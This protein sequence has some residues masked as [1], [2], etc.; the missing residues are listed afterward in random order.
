MASY[1]ARGLSP[2][3]QE[4][5][6]Y[7]DA[8]AI[9]PAQASQ[10]AQLMSERGVRDLPDNDLFKA[11]TGA[12]RVRGTTVNADGL[13]SLL[14]LRLTT[15][16][17]VLS[18]NGG[19]ENAYGTQ[20]AYGRSRLDANKPISF[21]RYVAPGGSW[22]P[23]TQPGTDNPDV[24]TYSHEPVLSTNY[25]TNP[26]PVGLDAIGPYAGG[27]LTPHDGYFSVVANGEFDGA[28]AVARDFLTEDGHVHFAFDLLLPAGKTLSVSTR[29]MSP[30]GAYVTEGD[31]LKNVV[32]TGVWERVTL[33]G[34]IPPSVYAQGAGQVSI[35]WRS[36]P[37]ANRALNFSV[38]DIHIGNKPEPTADQFFTGDSA[39]ARWAG[40]PNVSR[41]VKKSYGPLDTLAL[42]DTPVLNRIDVRNPILSRGNSSHWRGGYNG[43]V[44]I[45]LNPA[46]TSGWAAAHTVG[47]LGDA[48]SW[49]ENFYTPVAPNQRVRLTADVYVASGPATSAIMVLT[50]FTAAG[51][52]I[53]DFSAP[54]FTMCA[55]GG[56]LTPVSLDVVAPA[57]AASYT[58][59]FRAIN[60][61]AGTKLHWMNLRP[62]DSSS[63]FDGYSQGCRW[64]DAPYDSASVKVQPFKSDLDVIQWL[65]AGRARGKGSPE[66]VVLAPIGTRYVDTQ[67]T[68]GAVEWMKFSGDNTATG[69]VVT[70]GDTKWRDID[71]LLNATYVA[72]LSRTLLRRVNGRVYLAMGFSTVVNLSTNDYF[73]LFNPL[74]GFFCDTNPYASADVP[75][76]YRDMVVFTG[77]DL[78]VRLYANGPIA[79][80]TSIRGPV[81]WSA[82][83]N[84][85]PWPVGALPGTPA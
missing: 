12:Y 49:I 45:E 53:S 33:D 60:A 23:W 62:F 5:K 77:R 52:Y 29:Y 81:D 67:A 57:N 27:Q 35:Q 50:A 1:P 30:G 26:T 80:G 46:S 24:M 79:V 55:A 71:S 15:Q 73:D 19:G 69:W 44:S 36:V 22:T 34:I 25:F 75:V 6:Q 72:P 18:F 38:R 4:L 11:G 78:Q 51:A 14:D 85:I 40:D 10:I 42:V 8:G 83:T 32:G 2:Y 82:N 17:F 74:P 41:S 56:A 65:D 47:N 39:G 76:P 84:T 48:Q 54:Q 43:A 61:P 13:A 9:T 7:I 28:Y 3:D 37:D 63:A 58:I 70:Q 21:F 59:S 64:T 16:A 20:V 66:G 68:N 31:P